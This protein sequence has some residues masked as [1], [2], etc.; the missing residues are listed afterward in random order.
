MS[1]SGGVSLPPLVRATTPGG[2]AAGGDAVAAGHS[3]AAL[4]A[5]QLKKKNEL[6]NEIEM[7]QYP[8]EPL[9]N[10][11]T[12]GWME[13]G[14]LGY[15][16]GDNTSYM[17]PTPRPI[18]SMR[19]PKNVPRTAGSAAPLKF[20]AKSAAAG[21]RHTLLW[22]INCY[23]NDRED[24]LC[25]FK[26]YMAGLNQRGLC[27]EP[28]FATPQEVPWLGGIEE[29]PVD[30]AAG[31]GTSFVV[32]RLGNVYSWG[33]GRFGVL[34]HG[35]E[36]SETVP[37]QIR[38]L[39]KVNII[40]LACG[41]AH[42]IATSADGKLFSW[43]RNNKGQ[44]SRGFESEKELLPGPVVGFDRELPVQIACGYDHVLALMS[45]ASRDG[46]TTRTIVYGW[47]DE[48]R[49][50]LGSGDAHYRWKPQENRWLT[51][52]LLKNDFTVSLIAAGAHHNMVLSKQSGQ[53]MSW[54]AGDYGQL[55]HGFMWDDA[56]PRI[57][58][59]L[60]S[61][62]MMAAGSRH[63]IA[64]TR[65]LGAPSQVLAWGYNG[66]GELGIGDVN[67]RTQPT[68]LTSFHRSLIKGVSCGYRHSVVLTTPRPVVAKE[69][70]ALRPFFSVVEE[71]VNKMVIKQVKK[72]MEKSGFEPSLLD[73]PDGPLPNQVGSHD[74]PLRID[75]FEPGLRYCMDSFV[76]PADWR[77]KGYEVCFSAHTK[78]FNLQS[79]CLACSRHCCS[80]MYLRPY[81]RVRSLGNTKCYCKAAGLCVCYWSVIRNKFDLTTGDDG[82]IGPNQ[83]QA[84][85]ERLRDPA[86]VEVED[87]EE[88][89]VA[90]A[91]HTDSEMTT[92]RI[93]ALAFEK[94]YR[95]YFDEYEAEEEQS[96]LP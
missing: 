49:G 3:K 83:V 26:L 6:L 12:F 64:V 75:K 25:E 33:H 87:V 41:A 62:V 34:G 45:M 21:S 82:L 8:V 46:T 15:P 91:G 7:L 94:W 86:P 88:C 14:R 52:L 22:Y 16:P 27:E 76:D 65:P 55:G 54:G 35:N 80:G 9:L 32:T 28:G 85:L 30:I 29:A 50:Q 5:A 37:K 70:P 73:D 47:G 84:L 58:N 63:S 53:I 23:P 1:S 38:S 71:N 44:C 18:A 72:L 31:D 69:D 79:V 93:G 43:G 51:K 95:N 10:V 74:R 92:P 48:S 20:V 57:I 13:D 40:K 19:Q 68:A 81:V 90:L 11:F 39:L 24:G 59:N 2:Q 4:T 78:T 61:V 77:R 17:E 89:L 56:K 42:V 96:Q 66:Y 60:K 67:L 36:L